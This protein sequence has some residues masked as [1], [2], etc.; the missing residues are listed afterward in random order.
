MTSYDRDDIDS[1]N[2]DD[3]LERLYQEGISNAQEMDSGDLQTYAHRLFEYVKE[4][5]ALRGSHLL[6]R[7]PFPV[8]LEYCQ[9]ERDNQFERDSKTRLSGRAAMRRVFSLSSTHM[10]KILGITNYIVPE[11]FFGAFVIGLIYIFLTSPAATV[12]MKHPTPY[13]LQTA[14]YQDSQSNC[15]RYKSSKISCPTDQSKIVKYEFL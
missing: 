2:S 3:E 11:Y 10:G 6:N 13:N 1:N 8:F 14:T 9:A 4:F 12:I 7:C 5:L 15:Y